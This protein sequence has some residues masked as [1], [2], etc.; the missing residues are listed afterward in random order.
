MAIS[1]VTTDGPG[2]SSGDLFIVV[3]TVEVAP[4]ETILTATQTD[5]TCLS[6]S[7]TMKRLEDRG[8]VD[9]LI[10]WGSSVGDAVK[11]W[12]EVASGGELQLLRTAQNLQLGPFV[13]ALVQSAQNVVAAGQL[14]TNLLLSSTGLT[15]VATVLL[16]IAVVVQNCLVADG[17]A[18]LIPREAFSDTETSTQSSTSGAS[19]P[20]QTLQPDCIK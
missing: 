20:P 17:N 7:Q 2:Y 19:C 1:T 11:M 15:A 13:P 9:S 14:I 16:I 3:P 10:D 4:I 12:P 8:S 5:T 6:T 18:F